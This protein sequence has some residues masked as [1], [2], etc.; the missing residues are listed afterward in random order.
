M[1]GIK[2]FAALVAFAAFGQAALLA[3]SFEIVKA[4]YGADDKWSDVTQAVKSAVSGDKLSIEAS[5]E[6]FGD[7][8]EGVEKTLKATVKY[9]GKTVA[10]KAK[11]RETLVVDSASLD[12]AVSASKVQ[13]VKAEYGA[14]ETWKDVTD[15]A[16]PKLEAD[17]KVE[18]S[19][20]V[21]GDPL[22]G[23]GKT[24]KVLVK[25]DGKEVSLSADENAT[26]SLDQAAQ[27][28]AAAARKLEVVKAEYGADGKWSDVTAKVQSLVDGGASSVGATNDNFGDPNEGVEKTLKIKYK[29]EGKELEK[30]ATEN[31]EVKL[32]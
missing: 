13:V 12:K 19:N 14:G 5:N 17:G 4:E 25:I 15:I 27:K 32:F 20:S 7:P 24:L 31:E 26:L 3:G 16:K 23:A 21:F 30:S 1:K 18:A 22:P 10:V 9:N 8:I 2:A 28:P 6:N 11:E 29:F